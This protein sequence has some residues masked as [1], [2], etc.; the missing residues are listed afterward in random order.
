MSQIQREI[1]QFSDSCVLTEQHYVS[2]LG[3]E[4]KREKVPL[5]IVRNWESF[6]ETSLWN[7]VKS[8]L[9]QSLS[10]HLDWQNTIP[11]GAPSVK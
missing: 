3:G 9:Y 5:L 2:S 10:N 6:T 4:K 7:A 1:S 8:F 11:Y